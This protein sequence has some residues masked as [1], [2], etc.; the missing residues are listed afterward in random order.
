LQ[1]DGSVKN[2]DFSPFGG[3][4][5]ADMKVRLSSF[6][7]DLKEKYAE[8]RVLIVGHRGALRSMQRMTGETDIFDPVNGVLYSFNI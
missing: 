2:Y 6:I 3:E 5:E 4:N 1:D 7:D 8:K